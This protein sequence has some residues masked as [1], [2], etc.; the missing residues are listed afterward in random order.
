MCG[1]A[2][3]IGTEQLVQKPLLK[4]IAASLAHRGPDDEG[5]EI[6]PVGDGGRVVGLVHR[7]LAIIDLSPAGHQPMRDETTDNWIVFNGEIYNFKA[8]KIELEKKGHAFRSQSDTE[9]ILKAYAEYGVKCVE[10]LR[11]MFAFAL[12]DARAQKLFL[13]VDRFGIKPLYYFKSENLFA[14]SSEVKALLASEIVPRKVNFEAVQSFLAFGA[15]QAP[16]TI[17]KGV[18]AMLPAQYL[19]Y[20]MESGKVESGAYWSPGSVHNSPQPPFN[21]RGGDSSSVPPLRLRGGQE[22]LR[23]VLE[24]TVRHHF[25]SDVPV[26]LFLSGG[27]DSSALAILAHRVAGKTLDSFSVTFEEE[28]YAEGHYAR[29]IGEKFCARHHELKVGDSDLEKLLPAALDAQDQPTIDGVN[30]YVISKAVRDVGIKVVLSGQGGDEVFGGYPTFRRIPRMVRWWKMLHLLPRWKRA[31]LARI[32][33][34]GSVARSKLAQYLMSDGEVSTFYGI[35]RQL[36]SQDAVATIVIP[37][38]GRGSTIDQGIVDFRFRGNDIAGVD[39]FN[40]IFLLEL[41]GYLA[42]MLLRDGD[43]MSMAHGLEVR[44]PYLDHVLVEQVMFIPEREKMARNI[45]KSLLLNT[46]R[47]EMPCEIWARKKMGFTFPWELWLRGR[48]RG[49]VDAVFNDV[50]AAHAVGLN[51]RACQNVWRQFLERRGGITWSR[52]WGLYV[53]LRWS[54]VHLLV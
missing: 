22:G 24:D 10:K 23:E 17:V 15:V 46:V 27:V 4:K 39:M 53:L 31:M 43:V 11:G 37:D 41:R 30:A 47:D 36:F 44:V 19:V 2:G 42:N 54:R 50:Q 29:M 16:L 6:V 25:V 20:E 52:M 21:L 51:I 26:G 8:V 12:F 7:R 3:I 33:G 32:I 13:A 9:V 45:P 38:R 5:I 35:A 40:K 48:L 14:F 49:Q 1:I 18:Q 34:E 28:E